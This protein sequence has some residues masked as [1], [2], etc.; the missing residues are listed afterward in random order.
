[1][2]KALL[3]NVLVVTAGVMIAGAILYY[4]RDVEA[5]D[6]IRTGFGN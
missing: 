1:M 6:N 3:K 4:G 2:N 5:I